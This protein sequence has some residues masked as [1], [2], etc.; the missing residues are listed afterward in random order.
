M[1][2]AVQPTGLGRA[3]EE[4]L[5]KTNIWLTHSPDDEDFHDAVRELEFAV[6]SY[7][8]L[9]AN[10]SAKDGRRKVALDKFGEQYGYYRVSREQLD[11]II[12]EAQA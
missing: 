6:N 2:D 9:A 10:E 8:G 3:I 12:K 5:C 7:L 4:A 1:T 11:E